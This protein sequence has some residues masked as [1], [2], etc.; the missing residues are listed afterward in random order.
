M[1]GREFFIFWYLVKL[2]VTRISASLWGNQGSPYN[3][4][5]LKEVEEPKFPYNPLLSE[6]V[7]VVWV[8]LIPL[9]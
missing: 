3:P 7:G 5:L 4:L 1:D 6:E 8:I 2:D 9:L